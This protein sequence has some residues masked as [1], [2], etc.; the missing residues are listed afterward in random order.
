MGTEY[1]TGKRQKSVT[2]I[3]FLLVCV[4]VCVYQEQRGTRC[5]NGFSQWSL[6]GQRD[7]GRGPQSQVGHIH[8]F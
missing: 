7:E 3:Y 8:G 2:G 4:R 1:F 5:N 6:A